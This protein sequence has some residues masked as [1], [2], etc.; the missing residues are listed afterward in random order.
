METFIVLGLRYGTAFQKHIER[1]LLPE[2][3]LSVLLLVAQGGP[4]GVL[5][6]VLIHDMGSK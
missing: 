2:E 5:R 4:F 3:K 6:I 1:F